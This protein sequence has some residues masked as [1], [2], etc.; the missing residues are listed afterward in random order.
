MLET[1]SDYVNKVLDGKIEGNPTVGRFLATA[2]SSLPKIDPATL[3]KMINNSNQDLLLV[4][5]LANLTR[6][7]LHLAEKLQKVA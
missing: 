5:Y 3:E 6:T 2:M 4:V 1:V 7:Q